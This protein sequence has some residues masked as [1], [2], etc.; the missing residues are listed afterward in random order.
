MKV[1]VVIPVYNEEKVIRECLISLS[2]Q[3]FDNFEVLV[4]DDG[5][6]DRTYQEVSDIRVD[7]FG[8]NLRI[9]KQDHKGPATARNLGSDKANG[10]VLVFVD[11]DMTFDKLFLEKLVEP[12]IKGKAKGT[13]SCD[14]YVENWD[15][16][17]ARYWSYNRGYFDNRLVKQKR[18]QKVFRA[19]LKSEFDLVGGFDPGGYTDDYTLFQKLGY[20]AKQATGAHFYH[21]NPDSLK[22]VF[23]QARW[24]AKREYKF[25]KLGMVYVL[26][27][28]SLPVSFVFGLVVAIRKKALGYVLFKLVHDV[29]ATL[30][31]LEYY[32]QGK[33][34]K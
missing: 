27:R 33:G 17:W 15:K 31:I 23:S 4:V 1:S 11:A 22:E 6:T 14:E 2:Q 8:K 5:S 30:G 24:A 7:Y 29:A 16:P 13:F 3:S 19:I 25:G 21:K 10:E 20:K 9:L 28:F 18:K 12:I 34:S 32:L 26:L